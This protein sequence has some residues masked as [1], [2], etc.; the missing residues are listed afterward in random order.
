[1]NFKEMFKHIP[2]E[3]YPQKRTYKG[4][5]IFLMDKFPVKNQETLRFSIEKVNSKYPQGFYLNIEDGYIKTNGSK[6]TP[7]RKESIILFW[8]DSNVLNAKNIEVQIFTKKNSIFIGNILEDTI[9]E[10]MVVDGTKP[11]LESNKT[12]KYPNG[13][14]IVCHVNS[15]QYAIGKCNGFAMYS[16]DIPN[17]KHYFCNDG[18]EDEDFDDIIF[19]VKRVNQV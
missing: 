9:Y 19:T 14:K 10:E 7:T 13:K 18:D 6:A 3:K 2:G 1:M 16:E 15:E 8:E 5:T 17:G 4:R 12:I 11:A